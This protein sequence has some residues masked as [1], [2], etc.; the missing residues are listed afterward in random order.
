MFGLA[1]AATSVVTAVVTIRLAMATG[2]PTAIPVQGCVTDSSGNAINGSQ[3][4]Q[5]RL[6]TDIAGTNLVWTEPARAVNFRS[7]VFSETV[8]PTDLSI[9]QNSSSM[10]LGITIGSD[11]ELSPRLQVGSAPYAV[12]AMY[13]SV[14]QHANNGVPPGTVLSFAGATCPAGTIAA[15]GQSYQRTGTY[16]A[17]YAAIGLTWGSADG[18]HFNA[19]NLINRFLRGAGNP[20]DGNGGTALSV[21]EYQEGATH[22]YTPL[23][24]GGESQ[25][26]TH[27]VPYITGPNGEFGGVNGGPNPGGYHTYG[28]QTSTQSGGPSTD[29][30]HTVGSGQGDAE[31]RPKSYGV[32]YCVYY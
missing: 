32:T 26:H 19:P 16:A 7:C 31:T 10:Y 12:Q 2:V 29:H 17:L 30:T 28:D 3:T 22:V 27:T 15:D 6:Y 13:A 8:N 4:V 14:A 23:T 24:T 18:D 20:T 1:L 25:G 5:F 9:F 21:G 11:A